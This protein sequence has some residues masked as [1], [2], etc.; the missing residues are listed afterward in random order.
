M[1]DDALTKPDVESVIRAHDKNTQ[2][3]ILKRIKE[4]YKRVP[5]VEMED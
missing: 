2:Q 1:L 4:T 3:Q 5:D